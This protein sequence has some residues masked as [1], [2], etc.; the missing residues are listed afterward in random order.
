LKFVYPT[1][2]KMNEEKRAEILKTAK[3]YL[4]K[5]ENNQL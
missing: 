4:E 2:Y 3:K 5:L 1:W